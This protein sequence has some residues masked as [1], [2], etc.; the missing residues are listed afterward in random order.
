MF[1]RSFIRS[2]K[3]TAQAITARANPTRESVRRSSACSGEHNYTY[4]HTGFR[5][6][7]DT[8]ESSSNYTENLIKDYNQVYEEGKPTLPYHAALTA[9]HHKTASTAV[10]RFLGQMK[11]TLQLVHMHDTST[12]APTPTTHDYARSQHLLSKMEFA[13]PPY[14]PKRTVIVRGTGVGVMN[15]DP[16]QLPLEQRFIKSCCHQES[17]ADT[18]CCHVGSSHESVQYVNYRGDLITVHYFPRK[19]EYFNTAFR[20]WGDNSDREKAVPHSPKSEVSDTEIFPCSFDNELEDEIQMATEAVE[21]GFTY[22]WKNKSY[23]RRHQRRQ[24]RC[25]QLASGELPKYG[26]ILVHVETK[27]IRAA[28]PD[29][30]DEDRC[31]SFAARYEHIRDYVHARAITKDTLAPPVAATTEAHAPRFNTADLLPFQIHRLITHNDNLYSIQHIQRPLSDTSI[32]IAHAASRL[33]V[34]EISAL[35]IHQRHRLT[36]TASFAA[37]LAIRLSAERGYTAPVATILHH[38]MIQHILRRA[39]GSVACAKEISAPYIKSESPFKC[40]PDERIC[41]L[42]AEAELRFDTENPSGVPLTWRSSGFNANMSR[43]CCTLGGPIEYH[44][45]KYYAQKCLELIGNPDDG[46]DTAAAAASARWSELDAQVKRVRRGEMTANEVF[47]SP[48]HDNWVFMTHYTYIVACRLFL[49]AIEFWRDVSESAKSFVG[50]G[51]TCPSVWRN[52]NI[53][54]DSPRSLQTVQ[55]VHEMYSFILRTARIISPEYIAMFGMNQRYMNSLVQRTKYLTYHDGD[56]TSALMFGFLLPAMMTPDV[57]LDI[58]VE[59]H[60][61]QHPALYVKMSDPVFGPLKKQFK[62]MIPARHTG[63]IDRTTLMSEVRQK[64][65]S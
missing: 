35:K 23:Q 6:F 36:A 41:E 61:F 20:M 38:R 48:Q 45:A 24:R 49:A 28:N 50:V 39:T 7:Q 27:E 15:F 65:R 11:T 19:N 31:Q 42:R 32:V 25:Q 47:A 37:L 14:H 54:K 3:E 52:S 44:T 62:D 33:Q 9:L 63:T 10:T 51:Q 59:G 30:N 21:E 57:H 5:T 56:E 8:H 64:Y 16:T 58:F 29:P 46:A 53:C 34:T 55:I 18:C 17:S 40:L 2:P 43:P 22:V 4:A 13:L 1:S 60:I 12:S 26:L